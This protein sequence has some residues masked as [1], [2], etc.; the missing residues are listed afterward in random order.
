MSQ[1]FQGTDRHVVHVEEWLAWL[2]KDEADVNNEGPRA[3]I[4]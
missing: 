4:S 3:A 1:R 2:A